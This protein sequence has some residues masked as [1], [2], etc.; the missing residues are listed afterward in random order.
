MQ[1]TKSPPQSFTPGLGYRATPTGGIP[2]YTF[3][4]AP[5]PPNPSGV[6]ISSNGS[7]AEIDCPPS[8]PTGTR[9]QVLVTDSSGQPPQSA[10]ASHTVR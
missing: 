3:I 1:V 10:D 4:V 6:T 5:S 2:P 7:F 9:I 8:T